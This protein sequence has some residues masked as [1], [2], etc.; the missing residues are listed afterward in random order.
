M[1][2]FVTGK[3]YLRIFRAEGAE[4]GIPCQG[5]AQSAKRHYLLLVCNVKE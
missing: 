1:I 2:T 4:M 5:K 3:N